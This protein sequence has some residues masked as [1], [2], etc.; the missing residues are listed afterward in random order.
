[1]RI[2][3]DKFYR[4]EL[5]ARYNYWV[6][7]NTWKAVVL[8]VAPYGLVAFSSLIFK[9]AWP[10]VIALGWLPVMI[11]LI[12]LRDN[13]V[14]KKFQYPHDDYRIRNHFS[15]QWLRRSPNQFVYFQTLDDFHA[16]VHMYNIEKQFFDIVHPY[17]EWT[18]YSKI[19][20]IIIHEWHIDGSKIATEEERDKYN[21]HVFEAKILLEN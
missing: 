9:S 17:K 1:M 11:F 6:E 15:N 2:L 16:H 8:L 14:M 20:N 18:N 3:N 21:L 7:F 13:D 12:T 4:W 10:A 19:D 5:N